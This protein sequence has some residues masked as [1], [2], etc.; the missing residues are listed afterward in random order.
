MCEEQHQMM[1]LSKANSKVKPTIF[2][3]LEDLKKW[4]NKDCLFGNS[5]T[6]QNLF[7]FWLMN[8]K[9]K[10]FIYCLTLTFF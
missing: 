5:H 2:S 8:I 1:L 10:K 7:L 3:S 6:K 9:R 4:V